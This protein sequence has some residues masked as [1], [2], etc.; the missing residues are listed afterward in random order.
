MRKISILVLTALTFIFVSC[1]NFLS[2]L[3]D[4]DV[5]M[6]NV[7]SNL[8]F[9]SVEYRLTADTNAKAARPARRARQKR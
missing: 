1:G 2:D 3:K 9:D 5:R 8:V 4:E 6:H 7:M